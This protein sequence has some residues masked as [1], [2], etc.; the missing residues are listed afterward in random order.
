[1]LQLPHLKRAKWRFLTNESIEPKKYF[2]KNF[3]R[4]PPT[5]L[6]C[7]SWL[8]WK[9]FAFAWWTAACARLLDS[10][11]PQ[12]ECK[13]ATA[14]QLKVQAKAMQ[15]SSEPRLRWA[16]GGA[17]PCTAQS[18]SNNVSLS[19]ASPATYSKCKWEPSTIIICCT[20]GLD[21]LWPASRYRLW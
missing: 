3:K 19:C 9:R 4:K 14:T 6:E 8:H 18:I 11:S 7:C 20:A 15:T 2:K 17:V 1:M 10:D 5:S 21:M 13:Q 16:G 12:L